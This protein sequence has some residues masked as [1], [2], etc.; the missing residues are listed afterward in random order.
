MSPRILLAGLALIV[1]IPSFHRFPADDSKKG[2]KVAPADLALEINV[3]RT[4]YY[5]K[6]TPEQ[7]EAIQKLAKETAGPSKKRKGGKVSDEYQ[8]LLA[9]VRDA[10]AEDDDELIE[11]LE[12]KLEELSITE[13][14]ELDE[15]VEL[16]DAARKR[17]PEMLRQLRSHQVAMFLGMHAEQI[18]DPRERLQ[19]ALSKVRRWQL[20]EWP[21]QRDALGEEIGI[22]VG[23]VDRKKWAKARDAVIELLARA[24]TMK[25]DE[26]EAKRDELGREADRIT[27]QAGPMAVLRNFTEHALAEMLSNPRLDA[28]L[29]ARAK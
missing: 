18:V 16:T 5:L 10:L 21:E 2:D 14:P 7:V 27:R 9:E 13:S 20:A 29:K 12:D 23:G 26:Y 1:V 25:A 11:T 3:L 28:A 4:L 8:Q 17:A 19:E 6:A 24:R 15:A 22:L